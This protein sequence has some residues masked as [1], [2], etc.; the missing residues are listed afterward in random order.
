[1][2]KSSIDIGQELLNVPM[3]DMIREMA[4]A[5]ADAQWELDKS[6]MTVSELMSGQRLLRDLD[7]GQVHLDEDRNPVVVDSRVYFGYRYEYDD[8]GSQY[9]RAPQKVSMIE[10]GFVPQFYQFAETVIEVRISISVSGRTRERRVSSESQRQKA[11]DASVSRYAGGGAYSWGY[12]TRGW[13]AGGRHAYNYGG[14]KKSTDYSVSASSVDARYANSYSYNAEG[15]S[16]LRTRLVPVPP[17]GILQ[18][19][20]REV[21]DSERE[22]EGWLR[23]QSGTPT[24][25]PWAD[26]EGMLHQYRKIAAK[27]QSGPISAYM[28]TLASQGLSV[29]FD[30]EDGAD[31]STLSSVSPV[32]GSVVSAGTTVTLS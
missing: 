26:E 15:S 1:M 14:A 4:L 21:M 2:D 19:R 31:I 9:R 20:I 8:D 30:G 24:Q 10:L 23:E 7:S 13:R 16:L 11:A 29:S 27:P 32:P 28:S 12:G 3:G 5:I 18:D 25:L 6:S 22:F 17:P